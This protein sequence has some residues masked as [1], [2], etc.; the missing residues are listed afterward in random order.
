MRKVL[1]VTNIPT[2]YR[3]PLF[4][5]VATQLA[6]AG[7]D[8]KVAFA[9]AGYSR[10]QWQIDMSGCRFAHEILQS[11]AFRLFGSESASF[12]YPGLSG[13]L[14]RERPDVTV[15][16]GF[17]LGTVKLWMRRA[18]EHTNY[19]IWSGAIGDAETGAVWR[20]A[21][22]R[23]L[24]AGASGFVAYGTAAARYLESLGASRER[25]H[26]AINTVETEFFRRAT[27]ELREASASQEVLAIGDLTTRKAIDLLLPAFARVA[28]DRPAARLTLVG[29]GPERPR[30]E[31]LAA[32]LGIAGKVNFAGYQQ[33]DRIPGF[34]A[35]ARCLVFPTRFDIWGLVL[36]EA[37]AAGVPCIASV[38]AGA[39]EDLIRD[40][41]NGFSVDCADTT[42]LADRLARLL[43][44]EALARRLGDAAARLIREEASLTVSARGFVQAVSAADEHGRSARR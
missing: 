21:Q 31:S 20:Q 11:R 1:I 15:I 4:N 44:D 27:A 14:R 43:D 32:D 3:I 25:I 38:R 2:P 8:L 40:G 5:E 34:L 17:S 18:V 23:W 42:A 36:T 13:L 24:V 28:A 29:D 26:V 7:Y 19:V 35:R 22:R 6:A 30:L 41:S 39:T 16:T 10:R 12:T 37:M 9:A 33:R